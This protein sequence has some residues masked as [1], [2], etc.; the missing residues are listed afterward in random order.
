M[1]VTG[2]PAH[3]TTL[4]E[5]SDDAGYHRNAENLLALLRGLIMQ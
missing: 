2:I 4:L 3:G 1:N 5:G